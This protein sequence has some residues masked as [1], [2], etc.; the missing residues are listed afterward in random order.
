MRFYAC[1]EIVHIMPP[2]ICIVGK[3]KKHKS[4][5]MQALIKELAGRGI[6][7]GAIKRH[8][9]GDFE[10]DIKGKDSWKY[11]KAGANTVVISSYA[12]LAMIKNLENEMEIDELC[13]YFEDS[14]IVLADGFTKSNKPR[15][16]VVNNKEDIELFRRG[17]EVIAVVSAVCE[18]KVKEIADKIMNMV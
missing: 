18:D 13:R 1:G 7:V 15:I 9:H 16:I 14:D 4:S 17:C 8:K 3:S 6:K 12:K 10:I 5:L 2:V 11:A